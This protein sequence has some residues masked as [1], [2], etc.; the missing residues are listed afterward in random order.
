MKLQMHAHTREICDGPDHFSSLPWEAG[1]MA[2]GLVVEFLTKWELCI[3][4][5]F[6]ISALRKVLLPTLFPANAADDDISPIRGSGKN[7]GS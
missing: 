3:D 5:E 4:P 7:L 1:A 2:K 6:S